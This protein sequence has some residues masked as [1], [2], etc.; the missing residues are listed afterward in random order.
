[1]QAFAQPTIQ[2][3]PAKDLQ[4]KPI[5]IGTTTEL[6]I[7]PPGS[8]FDARDFLCRVSTATLTEGGPFTKFE[9]Y[10]RILALVSG[11]GMNLNVD[12]ESHAMTQPFQS[13][14]FKGDVPTSS[15]LIG[16]AIDD[17][18]VIYRPDVDASFERIPLTS[19]FSSLRPERS[20][21]TD[22]SA[23]RIDVLWSPD[24]ELEVEAGRRRVSVEERGVF[25]LQHARMKTSL[26]VR[27]L[28]GA[29]NLLWVRLSTLFA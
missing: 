29:G 20:G 13:I 15:E 8:N 22:Q 19:V 26:Q 27:A 9:G 7:F 24:S 23:I 2:V 14:K 11:A 17:F 6:A 1:M 3:I 28:G 25:I 5:R 16:G 10:M 18:N 12:G 4:A 21:S